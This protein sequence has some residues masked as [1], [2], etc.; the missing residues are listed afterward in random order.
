MI[1]KSVLRSLGIQDE[2]KNAFYIA[3]FDGE[4]LN[5]PDMNAETDGLMT[6]VFLREPTEDYLDEWEE[7]GKIYKHRLGCSGIDGITFAPIENETRLLVAYGVYGDVERADNDHQVILSYVPEDLKPYETVLTAKNIHESGPASCKER[8]FVHTGNT[9]FGVQNME[10][11]PFTGNI[12]LAVYPGKKPC[13]PN[14]KMFV[15][16]GSKA[17]EEQVLEGLNGMKGQ[18]LS[19]KKEG[20]SVCGSYFPY[21]STGMIALGDGYFYFSEDRKE[22]GAYSSEI[23]LY[24]YTEDAE[25]P[26]V[27]V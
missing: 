27:R 14:Y 8:F 20:S 25:K 23:H 2:I 5:R 9:T 10:Y 12:F 4:K 6:T 22:N 18:V 24:R 17:P 19:L 26:F 21:G 7:N 13:F 1:G 11:D 15:I 16:D 3:I